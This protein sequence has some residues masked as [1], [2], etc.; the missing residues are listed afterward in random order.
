M[1]VAAGF[2]PDAFWHQSPESFQ[3]AMEGVRDR[4]ERE[5]EM[6]LHTAWHTAAF[7]AAAHT[8]EGLRPLKFYLRKPQGPTEMLAALKALG[9]GSDMK[10]R[11]VPAKET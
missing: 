11:R 4:I 6:A 10:I 8:K 3:I 1:W 2:D 7:G 5:A 9:R